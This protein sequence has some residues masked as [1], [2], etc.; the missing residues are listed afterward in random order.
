YLFPLSQT[1]ILNVNPD[2]T[3]IGLDSNLIN[4]AFVRLFFF[5]KLEGFNLVYSSPNGQVKIFEYVG[6]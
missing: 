1:E 3:L 4:S 5:E 2:L 6:A